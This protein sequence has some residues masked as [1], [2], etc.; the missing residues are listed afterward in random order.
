[1][2]SLKSVTRTCLQLSSFHLSSNPLALTLRVT[3]L[4]SKQR[5]KSMPEKKKRKKEGLL[6]LRPI[7]HKHEKITQEFLSNGSI[8]PHT[9]CIKYQSHRATHR[10]NVR[11]QGLDSPPRLHRR[12]RNSILPKIGRVPGERSGRQ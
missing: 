10:I 8:S 9:L 3:L 11:Q 12:C 1:M 4:F 5:K 2:K 7:Q 6:R